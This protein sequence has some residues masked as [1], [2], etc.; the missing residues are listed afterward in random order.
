MPEDMSFNKHVEVAPPPIPKK[1]SKGL[2]MGIII[3]LALFA[4]VGYAYHAGVFKPE[5]GAADIIVKGDC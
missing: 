5:K 4:A 2:V 1:N 3:T